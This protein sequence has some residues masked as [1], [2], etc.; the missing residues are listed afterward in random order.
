[1]ERI[2]SGQVLV[3]DGATGTNLQQRGLTAGKPGEVWVFERPE[4]I[5]CL[6][7]D[8]IAAGADIILTCTFGGTSIRLAQEGLGERAAELNQRAAALAREAV[9]GTAVL[10]AGSIG[11]TGQMLKP[12]G[13][14][15]EQAC[16]DAYEAQARTLAEAGVDLLLIETQYDLTEASLAV[17]A[18]RAVSDLP[19]VC[20]FS[21]DRGTRT[22]MGVK[23]V[24]MAKTFAESVDLLGINCG[25]SLEDNLTALKELRS[26]TSLPIW[27]KP[28]AG[29]PRVDAEGRTIFDVT[30]EAMG[31]RVPDWLAAG[32]N[33][34]GGCCGSS[35]EH[36]KE[37]S[38]A[39][40]K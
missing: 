3:A 12:L 4:E 17:R 6:H 29:L 28:N 37:I 39:A 7:R 38:R 35:P 34:V 33:V 20:S 5:L 1:M 14:M 19:L 16:Y 36:V 26:A 31:A 32:A 11:P 2:K 18:A 21:Y 24:Q 22:M 27:F 30:P 40:K 9:Q 10:V 15:E 23:P 8:F 13:S 25:K